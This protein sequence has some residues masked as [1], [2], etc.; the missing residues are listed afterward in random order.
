MN[1]RI[2]KKKKNLNSEDFTDA[3]NYGFEQKQ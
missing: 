2:L 1:T 3:S